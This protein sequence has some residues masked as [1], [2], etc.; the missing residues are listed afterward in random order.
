MEKDSEEPCMVPEMLRAVYQDFRNIRRSY[1]N[2]KAKV[3]PNC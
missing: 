1:M 2:L 3:D